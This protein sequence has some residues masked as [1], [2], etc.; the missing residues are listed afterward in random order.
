MAKT[1]AFEAMNTAIDI[2]LPQKTFFNGGEFYG[3]NFINLEYIR[4]FFKEYPEQRQHV[5]ISIKGAIDNTT[6]AP[7]PTEEGINAS[8]VNVLKY[9][10]D[11]DFFEPARLS[12]DVPFEITAKALCDAVDDGR[13]KGYTLSEV[14]GET[15]DQFLK[16]AKHKP[17]AVE[18]EFSLFTRDAISN[19]VATIAGANDI[20][21]IAYSPLSRGLL[22]GEVRSLA[23][24]PEGDMRRH[25]ERFSEENIVKNVAI[26]DKV[27]ALA[28]DKGVT[29]AQLAL[30]WLRY[31]SGKTLD[32]VTYPLI[33]PIPSSSS[34]SR[35]EENFAKV[36]LSDED[37]SKI[38]ELV[39]WELVEGHRY[40]SHAKKYLSV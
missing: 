1:I 25:F 40:N 38:Q 39:D 16:I 2:N 20:P 14:S 11:L 3:A 27:V 21:I 26:A 18:V 37:Y 19:G 33:L 29:A 22:T 32:G 23:D 4:D 31:H 13:I 6:L 12:P 5:V 36:E 17:V 7:H 34:K 10:P 30:A 8:L 9:I 15:L 35:V 28:K 24:I